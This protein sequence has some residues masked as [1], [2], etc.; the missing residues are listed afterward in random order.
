MA[1]LPWYALTPKFEVSTNANGLIPWSD[2]LTAKK[3]T[4][5]NNSHAILS[6]SDPSQQVTE[7]AVVVFVVEVDLVDS[8]EPDSVNQCQLS[9]Q[10]TPGCYDALGSWAGG[11]VR[12]VPQAV[13]IRANVAR[14]L[15]GESKDVQRLPVKPLKYVTL[16]QRQFQ[17]PRMYT[18]PT[19]WRTRW[20]IGN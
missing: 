13:S 9:A 12:S 2:E 16:A 20:S 8:F 14:S 19:R 11:C 6:S 7:A 1:C 4:N 17:M 3:N 5:R 10:S 15:Q 18:E